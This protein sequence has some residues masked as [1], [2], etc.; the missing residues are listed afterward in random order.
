MQLGVAPHQG[1]GAIGRLVVNDQ[2]ANPRP[3]Q[4]ARYHR[5]SFEHQHD[6]L[7]L[8][9]G[10]KQDHEIGLVHAHPHSGSRDV[11]PKFSQFFGLT[12]ED[13]PLPL[14]VRHPRAAASESRARVARSGAASILP[15]PGALGGQ[16]NRPSAP[17]VVRY[18]D[19]EAARQAGPKR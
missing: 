6:V 8:V 3:L 4:P 9:V 15:D 14:F 13:H 16:A 18:R 2:H 19:L 11:L 12:A 7:R 5:E 1:A 17:E 10:R